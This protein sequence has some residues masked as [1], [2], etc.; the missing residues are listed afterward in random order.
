MDLALALASLIL[1][2]T[3]AFL[4]PPWS[5]PA[6]FG[7]AACGAVLIRRE[8]HAR[9][10]LVAELERRTRA[11]EE[12]LAASRAKSDYL[13]YMSHELRTPMNGI[14]G[15]AEILRR[16][17]LPAGAQGRLEIIQRSGETLLQLLDDLVD[18]GKVEAGKLEIRRRP[19]R[20]R[21]LVEKVCALHVWRAEDKGLD[22]RCTIA[23]E[24]PEAV[25]GDALR[26]HQVLANLVGNAVKF[27]PRGEVEV[28]VVP[29]PGSAEVRFT[30]R[31][32]GIGIAPKDQNRLFDSFVQADSSS[33]RRYGGSGLGLAIVRK[34]VEAMA[35]EVGFDSVRGAG[36]TFWFE[37]PLPAAAASELRPDPSAGEVQSLA[38]AKARILLVDDDEINRQV[39]H[40]QLRFLGCEPVI[41]ASGREA[42]D[43]LAE[44][45]FDVVLMDC[46]MPG[47]DGYR[48]T[49]LLR[50]R[51]AEGGFGARTPVIAVTAH[52]V[53]GE[54]ERCLAAGM[55]DYLAKP[56]RLGELGA[57]LGRWLSPGLRRSEPAA[58]GPLPAVEPGPLRRL[59]LLGESTGEDLLG[60]VVGTYR[61]QAPRRIA[62]IRRAVDQG[63]TE[64][65]R[66]AAHAL[67]GNAAVLGGIAL[68][69]VCRALQAL[70]RQ[71]DF[72]GCRERLAEL[73]AAHRALLQALEAFPPDEGSP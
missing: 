24:I 15:M 26:L 72:E 61:R 54:R 55:D 45:R 16:S 29:A 38:A 46:Q 25:N 23:E 31:D 1:A 6:L 34:M 21:P 13:A 69:E 18:L 35:G 50:R 49:R 19:F 64:A 9:S 48:T 22:L 2:A 12:A 68:G 58:L 66:Q 41:L 5:L 7:A 27:T 44:E 62:G 36:S 53:S 8:G 4:A 10:R 65:L 70:A 17:E 11:A 43:R 33:A 47:L 20:L 57:A 73:D 32:T 67:G 52:A 51:E 59:Q 37:L 40:S 60:Q 30:V 63:A 71:G 56:F 42:L 14:L 3:A 28:T 39:G